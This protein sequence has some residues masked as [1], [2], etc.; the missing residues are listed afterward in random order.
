MAKLTPVITSRPPGKDFWNRLLPVSRER[1]ATT[2]SRNAG[3][4]AGHG[5]PAHHVEGRLDQHDDARGIP[6]DVAQP[7]QVHLGATGL[8]AGSGSTLMQVFNLL[9]GHFLRETCPELGLSHRIIRLDKAVQQ[10][11]A[12]QRSLSKRKNEF[13]AEGAMERCRLHARCGVMHDR[14]CCPWLSPIGE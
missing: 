4:D 3:L 9:C 1:V 5:V 12:L 13:C 7:V 6:D 2:G 14:E 11:H 8:S 10:W